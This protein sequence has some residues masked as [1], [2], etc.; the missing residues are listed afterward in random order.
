MSI[1]N[2]CLS[3]ILF[4]MNQSHNIYLLNLRYCAIIL[5]HI[6]HLYSP[7]SSSTRP[8][9]ISSFGFSYVIRG[10]PGYSFPHLLQ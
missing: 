2:M 8:S 4:T 10:E 9:V 3:K 7:F 6:I 5:L 1:T